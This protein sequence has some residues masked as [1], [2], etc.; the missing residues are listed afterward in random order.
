MNEND[1]DLPAFAAFGPVSE[2]KTP[3]LSIAN[4]EAI[5]IGSWVTVGSFAVI[6][7]LRPDRGINVTIGDGTYIGH[8][9]RLTAVT[10][11]TIGA[12]VLIADRVYISDTGHNY[13]DLTR[14]INQQGLMDGNEVE[15]GDGAWIGIGAAIVGNVRIGRNAIVGANA[16]VRSDVPD[17][18]VAIGNPAQIVRRHDGERWEWLVPKGT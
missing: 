2:L 12:N 6:E 11:V 3:T 13:D 7:A 10:R 9:H 18:S 16:V 17:F 15:I 14:P 4:P 8:F 1:P 5:H